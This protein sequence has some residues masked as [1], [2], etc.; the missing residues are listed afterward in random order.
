LKLTPLDIKKQEFKRV[1]R[2]LDSEEVG[3]FLDMVADEFETLTRE[4][5]RLEDEN[6]KLRTQLQDYQ[7]VEK[8]LKQTLVTAQESVLHSRENSKREA[9]MLVREAEL[10]AEKIIEEAKLKLAKLKNEL[11]VVRAQKDSF[12]RRLRH[13]LESQ[14]ELIGVLELDDLGFGDGER[15]QAQPPEAPARSRADKSTPPQPMRP[16]SRVD[17]SNAAFRATAIKPQDA[18]AATNQKA[19]VVAKED[20]AEPRISDHFLT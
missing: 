5:N 6:L 11:L 10:Q 13:L 8:S 15:R 17:S 16:A 2:G 14:L 20:A 4:R 7:S 1:M 9:D 18:H 19:A 3:A 12:A